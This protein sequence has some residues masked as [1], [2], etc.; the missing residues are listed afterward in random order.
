[1]P[2]GQISQHQAADTQANFDEDKRVCQEYHNTDKALK[3]QLIATIDELYIK[4]LRH[5]IAGFAQVTTR[6][7]IVYLYDNYGKLSP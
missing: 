4:A 6:Q 3:S 5:H 2:A 7:L 1:M